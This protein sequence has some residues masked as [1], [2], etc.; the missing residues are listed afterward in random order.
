MKVTVLDKLGPWCLCLFLILSV[1]TV[2]AGQVAADKTVTLIYSGNLDGEL[3]PCGCSAEGDFG[4][5]RRRDT[6]LER[7]R[8]EKPD[9][10][11]VSAGGLLSGFA[12]NGR[13]TN[14]YIL[15]GFALLNYDAI[16]LQWDDLQYGQEFLKTPVLPWVSSNWHDH[17]FA[18]E[19]RV[20]RDG[21]TVTFFSWLDPNTAPQQ[22]M[23]GEHSQVVS[24]S[25][26]LAK[27]LAQ[28]RHDGALTVLTTTLALQ[29][30]QKVLPMADIDVLLIHAKYEVYGEPKMS[31]KT[32]VLQ[33]GSRGMRLGRVD[34]EL[35]KQGRIAAWHH[36]VIALPKT[37]PDPKGLQQWYAEYNAQVKAN[38]EKMS[39]L[40]K[41]QAKGETPF[42]GAEACKDCHDEAYATWR[43]S[44]HAKAFSALEDV[45]KS[46]D[47]D[48]LQC[49]TVGFNKPGGFIDMDVTPSLI[50]VQ[51]ESCHGAAREHVNSGGST[52]VPNDA[53]KPI[54]M[55]AQ[56]HTQPHSPAFNFDVYWPQII[57][58]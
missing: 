17:G 46:F 26:A 54:E 37:I 31:G 43:N 50:N 53:W 35:D 56:C 25:A 45:N 44:H 15:K 36:Q 42:V 22:A 27:A 23:L 6:M 34:L 52:P 29:D 30:A 18:H 11:V 32:L 38:Y 24:D 5:I 1:Q 47:P 51:C 40:R 14:E 9:A 39:A 4:G 19:R 20:R 13:L 41:A 7:L 3:E 21:R 49:H 33:P 12:A 2:T 55:C 10:F 48:C 57:H 58:D 28:A 16:G 8:G